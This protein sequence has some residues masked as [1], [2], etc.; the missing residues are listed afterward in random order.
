MSDQEGSVT[1]RLPGGIALPDQ[2]PDNTLTTRRE[3]PTPEGPRVP[4]PVKED[5]PSP[6]QPTGPPLKKDDGGA[7]RP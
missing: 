2:L 4:T 7:Q 6:S 5:P 3:M 1:V